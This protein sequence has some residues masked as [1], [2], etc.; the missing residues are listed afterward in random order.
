MALTGGN[1]DP[2]KVGSSGEFKGQNGRTIATT[3]LRNTE[4]ITTS[5]RTG[6]YV[7]DGHLYSGSFSYIMNVDLMMVRHGVVIPP[8]S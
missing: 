5:L 6:S 8:P 2:R 3:Q 1:G 4:P 7:I